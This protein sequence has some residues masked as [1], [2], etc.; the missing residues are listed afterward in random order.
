MVK[1]YNKNGVMC[2]LLKEKRSIMQFYR[3]TLIIGVIV[4]FSTITLLSK[5]EEYLLFAMSEQP[6]MYVQALSAS[7]REA[8]NEFISEKA[9]DTKDGIEKEKLAKRAAKSAKKIAENARKNANKILND[10]KATTEQKA[11]AEKNAKEMENLASNLWSQYEAIKHNNK[12]MAEKPI[13]R[14][15][16]SVFSPKKT[17]KI[18]KKEVTRKLEGA[19]IVQDKIPTSNVAILSESTDVTKA[20]LQNKKTTEADNWKVSGGVIRRFIREQSFKAYSYSASVVIPQKAADIFRKYNGGGSLSSAD[21]RE[22]ENGYV[23]MD[24]YTDLDNGTWYWGYDSRSQVDDRDGTVSMR[25]VDRSWTEYS[26]DR[27]ENVGIFKR[28]DEGESAPYL[29][30]ERV[31]IRRGCL[32]GALHIDFMRVPFSSERNFQTFRDTQRWVDYVSYSEDVYSLEGTGIN[33]SSDPYHGTSASSKGPVI[34]NIPMYRRDAGIKELGSY[35]YDVW[36]EVY[37]S[38]DFDLYTIS[39]GAALK[40]SFDRISLSGIAGPTFNFM[41]IDAS[42]DETLYH[43]YNNSAPSAL[44]SW[45]DHSSFTRFG[46]GG[47]VQGTVDIYLLRGLGLGFFG[48]YDWLG[49]QTGSIGPSEYKINPNGASFGGTLNIAF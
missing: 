44:M 30:L 37:Q 35:S 29:Q 31:I 4:L 6:Y 12:E 36:N 5:S 24:D 34:D 19:A 22:Y 39:L 26:R 42:Y 9:A 21:N 7:K 43:S 27:T 2:V 33:A 1:T 49:N 3:I 41:D 48:R 47:F 17:V 25:F 10:P 23:Y 18:P 20:T 15:L 45:S 40:C 38:V 46:I 16:W 28:T 32:T 13:K 14:D 8:S 11:I